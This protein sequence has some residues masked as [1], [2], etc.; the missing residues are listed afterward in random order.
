MPYQKST[1]LPYAVTSLQNGLDALRST[2]ASGSRLR[3]AARLKISCALLTSKRHHGL[4]RLP[5]VGRC[6]RCCGR[7]GRRLRSGRG[8]P[9]G[10][11]ALRVRW[12]K[13]EKLS[14]PCA[15]DVAQAPHSARNSQTTR[16]ISGNTFRAQYR[17]V[18]YLTSCQKGVAENAWTEWQQ[19][20]RSAGIHLHIFSISRSRKLHWPALRTVDRVTWLV[21]RKAKSACYR[22]HVLSLPANHRRGL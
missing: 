18:Q 13:G 16:P 4:R 9:C 1:S 7:R 15:D 21:R 6:S 11:R 2:A 19:E 8:R 10:T 3:A 14:P 12:A 20:C 22:E 17:R 5:R